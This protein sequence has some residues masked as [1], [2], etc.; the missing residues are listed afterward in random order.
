[1][2]VKEFVSGSDAEK[3]IA[4]NQMLNRE[5]E[6]WKKQC[7]TAESQLARARVKLQIIGEIVERAL[8]E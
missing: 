6:Y 4:E 3:L 5:A 2:D 7:R 8:H 1:M